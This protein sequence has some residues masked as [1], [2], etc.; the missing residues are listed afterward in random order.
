MNKEIRNL[1]AENHII[2]KKITIKNN[3]RMIE[4]D[5]EVLVI[6]K[7]EH[8]LGPLYKYLKSR[9]FDYFPEIL[10]QT[11]N[12]DIYRYI[13]ETPL[14]KEEKANDIMK[15][16]TLLHSKTTFYNEIDENTYK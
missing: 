5:D 7:K 4:T 13:E 15:L 11:K 16:I 6:K 8:D 14:Q 9:S 12:Y 10:Y 3:I 1:L 2:I